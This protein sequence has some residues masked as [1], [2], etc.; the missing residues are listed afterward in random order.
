M[1][2]PKKGDEVTYDVMYVPNGTKFD[3]FYGTILEIAG[4]EVKV[5]VRDKFGT[6]GNMMT[7][8]KRDFREDGPKRWR[9]PA[10][11]KV[12]QK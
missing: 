5:A 8:S 1:G 2:S 4:Q 11:I 12:G 9:C 10:T 7:A 6:S 3:E